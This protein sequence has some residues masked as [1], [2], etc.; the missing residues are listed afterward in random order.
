MSQTLDFQA[1]RKTIC[2]FVVKGR[3]IVVQELPATEDEAR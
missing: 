2:P 3:I 1:A